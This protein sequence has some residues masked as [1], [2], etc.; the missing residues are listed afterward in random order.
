MVSFQ[1]LPVE[2]RYEIYSYLLIDHNVADLVEKVTTRAVLEALVPSF[3]VGLFRVNK[4]VSEEAINYFYTEN[5]F[6]L[7]SWKMLSKTQIDHFNL[8]CIMKSP[9]DAW[10]SKSHVYGRMFAVSILVEQNPELEFGQYRYSAY[11]IMSARQFSR[12]IDFF[13]VYMGR[14]SLSFVLG[15]SHH[16]FLDTRRTIGKTMHVIDLS[17]LPNVFRSNARTFVGKGFT[18]PFHRQQTMTEDFPWSESG[19]E[20]KEHVH[21]PQKLWNEAQ[22]VELKGFF[23]EAEGILKYNAAILGAIFAWAT[24]NQTLSIEDVDNMNAISLDSSISLCGLYVKQGNIPQALIQAV[25]AQKLYSEPHKANLTS[26]ANSSSHGKKLP[27]KDTFRFQLAKA[28]A[29]RYPPTSE[30]DIDSIWLAI[31]FRDRNFLC[32]RALH[33]VSDE[34]P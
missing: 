20:E 27:N 17:S 34:G 26:F 6:A 3:S 13:G 15:P 24:M 10:L 25:A 28:F 11:S 8:C 16:D 12:F 2:L 9:S 19:Y 7:I 32:W 29:G 22:K 33:Y 14:I 21:M 18:Y 23:K 31:E 5:A 4:A 1:S 30:A